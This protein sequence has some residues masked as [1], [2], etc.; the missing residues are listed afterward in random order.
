MTS[1]AFLPAR[2][3]PFHPP[4]ALAELRA[5]HPVSKITLWDGSEAWLVTRYTEASFI[6]R[7]SRFSADNENPGLPSL[8]PGRGG[9][10]GALS[11]I[12]EP[13]HGEI[14]RML[15]R[16]F[17][18]SRITELRPD[19]ERIVTGNIGRLLESGRPADFHGS[20]ALRVPSQVISEM[21]GLADDDQPLFHECT[22]VLVSRTLSREQ[23]HAADKRLNALCE[24]LLVER[25]REPRDDL[26]GRLVSNELCPGHLDLEEACLTTKQLI[27]AG[28]ETTANAISLGVL[29]MLVEPEWF[30]AMRELPEVVPTAVEELLRY[31][32]LMH[33][34]LPRVATE[35]VQ[36]GG[37]LIG[38]GEGVVVSLASGNRDEA[39]F[40]DPDRLDMR[41]QDARHHLTFGHGIHQCLGQWLAR[42][43]LQLALPAIAA[44]IPTL[45]LAV[46][47]SQIRFREDMHVYG[48][49]Q[50]PVTW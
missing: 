5:H 40:G 25:Q 31:H 23:H 6:L 50:L 10:R 43:E 18:T 33:T 17:L 48:V 38:A 35:D 11:R 41:R 27:V 29:T 24:R 12:D 28:H 2:R 30:R 16:D 46:P 32:T 8:G 9:T 34:G 37:T 19:I 26:L 42:A 21:L 20:F 44:R 7:D 15:G 1:K 4:E 36:V 14:R 49:H 22:R 13:R 3:H 39:V 47:F 45:R